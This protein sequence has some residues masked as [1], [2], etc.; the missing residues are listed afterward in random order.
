[1]DRLFELESRH[2]SRSSGPVRSRA[3]RWARF[4]MSGTT[5][6]VALA[7]SGC[8]NLRREAR[9]RPGLLH[10]NPT[11][12]ESSGSTIGHDL[13][14]M[15]AGTTIPATGLGVDLVRSHG[16]EPRRDSGQTR[17]LPKTDTE[18]RATLGTGPAARQGRAEGEEDY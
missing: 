2:A 7:L 14:R 8:G 17:S 3:W 18:T 11:G 16:D 6:V 10:R 1:M 15:P 9:D 13:R 12:P 5:L 4:M